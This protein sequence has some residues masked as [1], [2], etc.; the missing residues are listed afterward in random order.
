MILRSDYQGKYLA[1]QDVAS[2]FP[3]FLNAVPKDSYPGVEP[4]PA[5]MRKLVE[6]LPALA[7]PTCSIYGPVVNVGSW[8]L[9][10]T[11]PGGWRLEIIHVDA[12]PA[13][14]QHIQ[15]TPIANP[16]DYDHE[17]RNC[18]ESIHPFWK[19]FRAAVLAEDAE[20]VADMTHFPLDISTAK[21]ERDEPL[22]RAQFIKRFPQMLADDLTYGHLDVQPQPV[23]MKELVRAMP[24]LA[25][26]MCAPH[27]TVMPFDLW[28]FR[29]YKKTHWKLNYV[30]ARKIIE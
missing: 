27:G 2:N 24:T 26:E 19:K 17:V 18:D 28:T 6:A 11:V 21:K 25:K 12:F 10:F 29:L 22:S 13:S 8:E 14:M 1:I 4:K 23:S 30:A 16:N 7:K 9:L 5:S 3:Q 15:S 20:A